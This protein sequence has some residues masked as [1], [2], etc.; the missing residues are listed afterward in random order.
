MKKK[1]LI[2]KPSGVDTL[3][4]P[5]AG[6]NRLLAAGWRQ[7]GHLRFSTG[8][9]LDHGRNDGAKA[10]HRGLA[11]AAPNVGMV[12]PGKNMVL[13]CHDRMAQPWIPSQRHGGTTAWVQKRSTDAHHHVISKTAWMTWYN[14][15]GENTM[16]RWMHKIA[17]MRLQTPFTKA[18]Q[19]SLVQ[20]AWYKCATEMH[21]A[22]HCTKV[23]ANVKYKGKVEKHRTRH[24]S[25]EQHCPSTSPM[26]AITR[27][28]TVTTLLHCKTQWDIT[29]T[30][31]RSTSHGIAQR[32][33]TMT[34]HTRHKMLCTLREHESS[35]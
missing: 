4:L 1:A 34:H 32:H 5:D 15:L 35:W 6:S 18:W 26:Y 2:A 7:L 33:D 21:C 29:A 16:P 9:H 14:G 13:Q 8:D 17:K 12:Q 10:H 20:R 25:A 28:H 22:K 24:T 19:T 23:G 27:W 3:T 11:E 31:H 30:W